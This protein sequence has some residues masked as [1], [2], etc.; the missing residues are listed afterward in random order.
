MGTRIRPLGFISSSSQPGQPYIHS[1]CSF[2]QAQEDEEVERRA[3]KLKAT[4]LLFLPQ[5]TRVGEEEQAK[6]QDPGIICGFQ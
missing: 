4:L 6:T 2:A 5:E 3:L 1:F